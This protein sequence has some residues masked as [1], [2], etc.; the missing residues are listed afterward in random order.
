MI[1]LG[2]A[3]DPQSPPKLVRPFQEVATFDRNV[4]NKIHKI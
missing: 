1:I 3:G 2:P 4:S